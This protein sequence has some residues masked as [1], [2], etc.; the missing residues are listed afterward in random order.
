MKINNS[1]KIN[2]EKIKNSQNKLKKKMKENIT[3]SKA[4]IERD[5]LGIIYPNTINVIQGKSGVHK[6]RLL[7]NMCSAFLTNS[8]SK[9]FLGFLAKDLQKCA[10]LYVDTERNLSDQYPFALQKIVTSAGYPKDM[11][12]HNFDFISLIDVDRDERFD[13]LKNYLENL[14]N[15]FKCHIVVVLD[16]ITDCI[17]NFNDPKETLKLIDLLNVTINNY[18]VTFICVIH[19]NPGS[20]DKARG[21]LGTEITNKASTVIQIGFEKDRAGNDTE[22]IK[23]KYLK[24]RGT[25]KFDPF[26]LVYSEEANGLIPAENDVVQGYLNLKRS[27]ADMNPLK[28]FLSKTLVK[29]MVKQQLLQTLT[30]EF[31][32]SERTI[33]ERLKELIDSNETIVNSKEEECILCKETL[34]RKVHYKLQLLNKEAKV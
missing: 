14:R 12:V 25:K 11:E 26:Y 21:H 24:K 7:E 1:I 13:T 10:L 30:R 33:E 2:L 27:K 5:H 15:K 34:N 16:V 17:G 23:V 3:F 31:K 32:C 22:L 20:S 18:D 19:E 9:S 6:S 4:I 29:P 8:A 28:I